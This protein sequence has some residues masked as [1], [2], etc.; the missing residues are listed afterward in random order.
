[1]LRHSANIVEEEDLP[2]NTPILL[3][4]PHILALSISLDFALS[5]P[6]CELKEA[7]D[8]GLS[9]VFSQS[10]APREAEQTS[11]FPPPQQTLGLYQAVSLLS[12]SSRVF[13]V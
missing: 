12:L 5:H 4:V 7:M 11:L 13:S 9:P 3:G 2:P 10:E 6:G 1:M 8:F